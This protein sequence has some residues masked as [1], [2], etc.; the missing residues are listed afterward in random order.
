L[1][2][3]TP[4]VVIDPLLSVTKVCSGQL[5][6][7]GLVVGCVIKAARHALFACLIL[8]DAVSFPGEELVADRL[9]VV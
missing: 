8:E 5:S 4:Q 9:G 7:A 1:E 6:G 3:F 2:T